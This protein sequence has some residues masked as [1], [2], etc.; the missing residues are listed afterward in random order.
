[1]FVCRD[2]LTRRYFREYSYNEKWLDIAD[3]LLLC[4]ILD[5][6]DQLINQSKPDKSGEYKIPEKHEERQIQFNLTNPNSWVYTGAAFNNELFPRSSWPW[7]LCQVTVLAYFHNERLLKSEM[8]RLAQTPGSG[9]VCSLAASLYSKYFGFG[10]SAVHY[11]ALQGLKQMSKEAFIKDCKPLFSEKHVIGNCTRHF[12]E[13]FRNL[14]D[15]DVN[16]IAQNMDVEYHKYLAECDRLLRGNYDKEFDD[17][18]P[19]LLGALWDA[20]LNSMT[21]TALKQLRDTE[22]AN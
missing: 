12:A 1:M 11:F 3:K 8:D 21:E 2:P 14:N 15:E 19:E 13:L 18:L 4:G 10:D 16:F 7:T 9:P 17:A 20:G 5:P 6:I 22:P